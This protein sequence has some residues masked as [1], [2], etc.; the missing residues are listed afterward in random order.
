M[1]ID[2]LNALLQL[3]DVL[4]ALQTL[5]V[6]QVLLVAVQLLRAQGLDPEEILMK[7]TQQI[8]PNSSLKL[9]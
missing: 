2:V 1:P 5:S 4:P 6:L 3:L 8:K 7:L 9:N